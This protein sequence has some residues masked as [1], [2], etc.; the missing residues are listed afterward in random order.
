MYLQASVLPYEAFA[1]CF[2]SVALLGLCKM[3]CQSCYFV[4]L[5]DPMYFLLRLHFLEPAGHDV[6]VSKC[7]G[8]ETRTTPALPSSPSPMLLCLSAFTTGAE[9]VNYS[10]QAAQASL[11][12]VS[13]IAA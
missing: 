10:Y 8:S 9:R 5:C 13:D 1:A 11:Y 4:T 7:G 2:R 3:I 6:V 12:D